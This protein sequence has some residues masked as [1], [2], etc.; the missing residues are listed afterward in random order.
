MK[1]YFSELNDERCFT[2]SN[3]KEQMKDLELKEL[4]VFE[5]EREIKSENFFCKAV[6]QC[7]VRD[8]D[9]CGKSCDDYEPRNKKNGCCINRA[10]CYVPTEK[11]KII[12][13]KSK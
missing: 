7:C 6:W 4:K 13:L 5:A 10:Y 3:I 12:K 9:T 11:F 2:I 8:M 1:V